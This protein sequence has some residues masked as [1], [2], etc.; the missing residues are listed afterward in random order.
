MNVGAAHLRTRGAKERGADG[1]IGTGE[2]TDLDRPFGGRHHGGE[3]A[4]AHGVRYP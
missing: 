2:L 3:D 4:V 1:K